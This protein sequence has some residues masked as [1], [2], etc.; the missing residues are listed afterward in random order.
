M[1]GEEFIAEAKRLG[2][3]KEEVFERWKALQEAGAFSDSPQQGLLPVKPQEIKP[4][5]RERLE[6]ELRAWQRQNARKTFSF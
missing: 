2:Y 3:P 6:A 5:E 1:T 4:E